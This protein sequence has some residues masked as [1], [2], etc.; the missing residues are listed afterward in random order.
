VNKALI[1]KYDDI[2]RQRKLLLEDISKLNHDQLNFHVASGTWSILNVC[3]HLIKAETGTLNYM[4][5]KA[6]GID[7]VRNTS[8]S[9]RVRSILLKIV[10]LMPIKFKAPRVTRIEPQ[11][12][13]SFDEVARNW[14][15][16][17]R[18]IEEF[19]GTL[20]DDNS[21]KMI[22][23]HPFAGRLNVIQTFTFFTDHVTHHT[24]QIQRIKGHQDF[25]V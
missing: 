4:R 18:E 7:N 24:Y 9:S 25:P 10:L 20:D 21:Q 15:K 5:K 19:I 17:R 13:L 3:T 6:L 22:F 23:R 2:E 11:D 16:L 14:D 12:D 8:L 1:K